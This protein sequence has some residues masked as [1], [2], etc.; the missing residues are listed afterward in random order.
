LV[1]SP[2]IESARVLRLPTGT[3]VVRVEERSAIARWQMS[4]EPSSADG[5][6]SADG[7]TPAT[8]SDWIDEAGN[9]FVGPD[10]PG[11][12]LPLVRGEA[13]GIDALSE[14]AL[15]ILTELTQHASL[16]EDPAAI[17]LHL[18]GLIADEDGVLRGSPAGFVLEI[19]NDGPRALL[20]RRLLPQRVARLASLLDQANETVRTATLIDLRYADRAVLSTESTSG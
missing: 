16:T 3:L 2:W 14:D 20:G 13:F 4:A 11:R 6:I 1:A 12:A 18:P 7:P 8:N 15:L 19:G 10:A 5:S 9:H 17:T